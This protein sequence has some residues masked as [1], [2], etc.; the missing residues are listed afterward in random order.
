MIMIMKKILKRMKQNVIIWK[1]ELR[2][3]VSQ[4]RATTTLRMNIAELHVVLTKM[5]LNILQVM[6]YLYVMTMNGLQRH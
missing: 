4:Q 1:M 6:I 5:G 3:L 2:Y